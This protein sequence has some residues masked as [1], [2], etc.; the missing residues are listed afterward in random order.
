MNTYEAKNIVALLT[1]A[2]HLK[3]TDNQYVQWIIMLENFGEYRVTN[4]R[5]Q[6]Y[7]LTGNTEAP[8][9]AFLIGK[10]V[11]EDLL[12]VEKQLFR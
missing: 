12:N 6:K 11:L 9:M 2:Y 8:T 3:F 10:N 5:L 1:S 4:E 7:I